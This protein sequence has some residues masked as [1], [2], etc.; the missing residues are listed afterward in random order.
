LLSGMTA[1]FI[2][3]LTSSTDLNCLAGL[4]AAA[5]GNQPVQ[6]DGRK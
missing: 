3:Q 1:P 4:H 5:R 6:S 2:V